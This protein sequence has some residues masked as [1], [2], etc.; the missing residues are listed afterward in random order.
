MELYKVGCP[1]HHPHYWIFPQIF[2]KLED[3]KSRTKKGSNSYYFYFTSPVRTEDEWPKPIGVWN[4]C[5][6]LPCQRVLLRPA[7]SALPLLPRCRTLVHRPEAQ[8]THCWKSGTL[9]CV[10]MYLGDITDFIDDNERKC[11]S[12]VPLLQIDFDHRCVKTS[13]WPTLTVHYYRMVPPCFQ[14][15][16]TPHWPF[17]Q[18]NRTCVWSLATYVQFE[19]LSNNQLQHVSPNGWYVDGHPQEVVDVTLL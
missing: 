2:L 11:H 1:L 3:S 9:L 5:C 18:G 6:W 4:Q 10:T 12:N 14:H 13:L 17:S 19:H 15:G 7:D 16:E 8:H